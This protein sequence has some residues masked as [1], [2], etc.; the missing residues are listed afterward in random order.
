MSLIFQSFLIKSSHFAKHTAAIAAGVLMKMMKMMMAY[1]G[2]VKVKKT[3]GK[4]W[5]NW[6]EN[7]ALV[8]MEDRGKTPKNFIKYRPIYISCTGIHFSL[9]ELLYT[10]LKLRD[11]LFDS[12]VEPDKS[13]EETLS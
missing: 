4:I 1:V 12:A 6:R 3:C 7:N 10:L 9:T 5:K 13:N 2:N 8:I 11:E